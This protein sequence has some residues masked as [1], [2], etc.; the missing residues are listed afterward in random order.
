VLLES[1]A[2]VNGDRAGVTAGEERRL[3]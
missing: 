2:Q 1:F 3:P